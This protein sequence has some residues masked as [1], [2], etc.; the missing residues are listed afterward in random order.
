M[1]DDENIGWR[2]GCFDLEAELPLD[3]AEQVGGGA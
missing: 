1:I 2:L 3:R